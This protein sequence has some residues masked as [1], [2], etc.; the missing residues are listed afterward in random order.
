MANTI[1]KDE[2][3]RKIYKG[4]L[5]AEER[6]AADKL[7][8]ELIE[9]IP[10]I[11]KGLQEKYGDS[12]D[13]KYF[14]GKELGKLL[15]EK[16]I[17]GRERIYFWQE[18]RS[19]AS[20]GENAKD[21]SEKRMLYEQ[22]F[23]LSQLDKET[24]EKLSWR[25]WQD[26]LDR[27]K[28][29]ADERI[30]DWIKKNPDKIRQDDWREFE[31]VLHN[32][33]KT[34]D[35]SFFEEDELYVL[36][37]QIMIIVSVWREEFKAFLKTLPKEKV[38]YKESHMKYYRDRYYKKCLAEKRNFTIENIR[39]LCKMFVYEFANKTNDAKEE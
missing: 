12:I 34:H 1:K 18:I 9:F 5:S 17:S 2:K 24:V 4:L 20:E 29:R 39:D 37:D 15:D 10:P 7:L 30:F 13:Y 23:I 3:G 11:E 25:Q 21:R 22:C 8:N 33:L 6:Q 14:L 26:L 16:N 31:K 27:P 35:T 38:K 36:F 28:N 32:Y 19:F